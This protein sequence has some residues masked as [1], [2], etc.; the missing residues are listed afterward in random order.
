MLTFLVLLITISSSVE[1]QAVD[2]AGIIG[3]LAGGFFLTLAT[4]SPVIIGGTYEKK[5]RLFGFTFAGI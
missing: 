5:C 1:S 3:G 4:A 2:K